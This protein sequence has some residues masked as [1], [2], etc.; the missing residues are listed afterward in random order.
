MGWIAVLNKDKRSFQ[1][2]IMSGTPIKQRAA[3]ALAFI[4]VSRNGLDL[5][6]IPG[7]IQTRRIVMA[8]VRQNGLALKFVTRQL[9]SEDVCLT[10]VRQNGLALKYAKQ[11]PDVCLAALRNNIAATRFVDGEWYDVITQL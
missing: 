3:R 2:Y 4:R 5:R 9:Q 1:D 10:A 7:R 8:A 11:S 6:W